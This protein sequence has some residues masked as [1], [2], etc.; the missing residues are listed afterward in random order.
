MAG[1]W[2]EK[3]IGKKCP[4]DAI[5]CIST[6]GIVPTNTEPT[7]CCIINSTACIQMLVEHV[8][9]QY[10]EH[11]NHFIIRAVYFYPPFAVVAVRPQTLI[12]QSGETHL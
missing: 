7:N 12:A 1:I 3:V 10:M 9:I 2:S 6:H 11:F 5:L 4:S 8:E